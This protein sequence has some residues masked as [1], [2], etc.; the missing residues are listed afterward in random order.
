MIGYQTCSD[1]QCD[2]PVAVQFEGT[3]RVEPGSEGSRR[4]PVAYAAGKYATVAPY[5]EG[6]PRRWRCPTG[7]DATHRPAVRV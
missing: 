7:S 2:M 4:G 3:I 5:L 6:E 1:S